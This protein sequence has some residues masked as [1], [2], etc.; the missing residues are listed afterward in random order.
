MVHCLIYL[1]GLWELKSFVANIKTNNINIR[2]RLYL[3]TRIHYV[4]KITSFRL[5]L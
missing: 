4:Y 1:E 2:G 3:R 5:H